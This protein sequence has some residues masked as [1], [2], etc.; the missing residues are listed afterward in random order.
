MKNILVNY[1]LPAKYVKR[2][3]DPDKI[4]Y[5]PYN[6]DLKKYRSSNNLIDNTLY[7]LII[8]YVEDIKNANKFICCTVSEYSKYKL[9]PSMNGV[10]L[11]QLKDMMDNNEP[12]FDFLKEV[13][14]VYSIWL[15]NYKEFTIK[16]CENYPILYSEGEYTKK[17][18]YRSLVN[19]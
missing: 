4:F 18:L 14:H 8:K 5:F 1:S 16:E 10:M 9:V 3:I 19:R 2:F 11:P 6:G 7:Q 13:I 12:Y 15:F 17:E